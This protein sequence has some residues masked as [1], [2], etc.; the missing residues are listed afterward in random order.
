MSDSP[1]L[2]IHTD[3]AARGNPG[4]AAFAYVIQ[5]E[6]EAPIEEAGLLGEATNNQAEYT[7]LVRALEHALRLGTDHR[8]VIHADSELMVKQM[9]GEYRVKDAGLRPLYEQACRLRDQ[10]THRPKIVH[11]RRHNNARADE[12]CNE[13]L[14]GRRSSRPP[15]LPKPAAAPAPRPSPAAAVHDRAVAYLK[16]AAEAWAEGRADSPSP[17]GV[18]KQLWKILEEQGVV[19][20]PG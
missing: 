9:L 5:R 11:V 10:F 8:L 19:R 7:A 17:E 20:A 6:G 12:L 14:D 4:P 3:G 18:W 2:K 15:S 1:T 13:V 16:T